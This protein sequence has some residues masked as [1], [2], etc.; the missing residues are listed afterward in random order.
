MA[1]DNVMKIMA[2]AIVIMSIN[3][4]IMSMKVMS[5]MKK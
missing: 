3:N 2:M 4:K 1:R 5:V